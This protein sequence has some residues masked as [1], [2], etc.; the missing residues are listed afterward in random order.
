V[1]QLLAG[2]RDPVFVDRS[3]APA[4][5]RCSGCG[6]GMAFSMVATGKRN[7]S[8]CQSRNCRDVAQVQDRLLLCALLSGGSN[9]IEEL[10]YFD[11]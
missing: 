4:N 11:L 7:F 6:D 3:H 5:R 10:G 1:L 8:R 9:G 2:M